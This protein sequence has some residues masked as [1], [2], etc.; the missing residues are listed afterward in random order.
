MNSQLIISAHPDVRGNYSA[1]LVRCIDECFACAQA[2]IVCADAC[3]AEPRVEQLR[4]CIRLNMDCADLCNT[5]GALASRR[6][7]S[8]RPVLRATLE[9]CALACA[10]CAEECERHAS[11]HEHCRICAQ[12]CRAC[13]DTCRVAMRSVGT[14]KESTA[15]TNPH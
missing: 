7:G 13:E 12:A 11:M 9:V 5:T 14:S 1:A 3:V 15:P 10:R 2:C 8:N 4:Q 6:T